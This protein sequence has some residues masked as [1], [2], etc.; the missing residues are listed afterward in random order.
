M[1]E[2]VTFGIV[3]SGWRAEFFARLAALLPEQLT[4]VG[5]AVRRPET[6]ERVT[7]AWRVPTY[8]SPAE[9]ASRQQPEFV[10]SSVPWPVNPEVIGT[11]VESGTPVLAET[12]PAPDEAGLRALWDRVGARRQVQV[13]EQYL[14]MPG[15]AAR[16]EIVRRGLI[17]APTSVQVSSTHGYHVVSMIRGLLGAGFGPVRVDARRFTAPLLDPLTRDGW[18]GAEEPQDATTTL[19]MLDFDGASGLY[20]FTDNQWHNRLRLRRIVVRGSHGEM[21]DDTVVRWGGPQTVLRSEIGRSHLGHDL[22]LDG[23]D[24]EHLT[25]EGEV[26]YRNPFLGLR[27]MDEEIAI[28]TLLTATAAWVRGEGPEPYPLAE[29]CQDHLISLAID[30][31]ADSGTPVVTGTE[32]WAAKPGS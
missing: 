29:G 27:L 3:G 15:H 16:R 32:A 26:V 30:R 28:A 13:A 1:S 25:F 10:I 11:L 23:F 20:D 8:L 14:L 19:A 9:L 17:G 6:A 18:T 4:L 5:A 12:P 31:A 21:A 24:T 2:P 22:N 7:A